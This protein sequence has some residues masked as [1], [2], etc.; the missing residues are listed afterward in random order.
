MCWGTAHNVCI[1]IMHVFN[2]YIPDVMTSLDS[3][4]GNQKVKEEINCNA[5]L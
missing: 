3:I 5:D 4:V 1:Y 2:I